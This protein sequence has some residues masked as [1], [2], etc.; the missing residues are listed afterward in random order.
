MYMAENKDD[1]K[2]VDEYINLYSLEIQEKL[3]AIRKV[4]KENVPENT[5][6]KISWRMPTYALYGNLV[7]FAAFQKHIGFY[8]AP[9]GIEVYQEQLAKY[10]TSKGAVQFP[11]DKPLPLDLIAEIVRYR[12]VQN[13]MLA[14]SKI[15]KGKTPK[16]ETE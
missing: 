15:K 13:T 5:E 6:E 4:I 7:H 1:F 16:T 11:L 8:P 9:D 14:E 10:K 12:V 2:T 3:Q